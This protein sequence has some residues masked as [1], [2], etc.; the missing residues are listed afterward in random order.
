MSYKLPEELRKGRPG[1]ARGLAQGGQGQ[2]AVGCR[3]LAVDRGGRGE[4]AGL[5]GHRRQ[6]AEGD[7]ARC[8][9]SPT[10]SRTLGFRDVLLLGMGGSS[11]GPEVFAE[12]F[13]SKPG[14]PKL[15]VLNSTDPA[16]IRAFRMPRS[17]SRRTLFLV[18]SKSGSTLEPNIFKQYSYERAKQ[19][20]GAAEAPKRFVAITDPGS[21]LEKM[22][23]QRRVPPRVPRRAEHRRP[24]FGV[25]G[26]RHGA[27]G[28]DRHRPA[29]VSRKHGRDGAVLRGERAAGREPG[30]DP[31]RDPR[32]C[33]S[34]AGAT[35]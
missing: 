3:R 32:D 29:R 34:A 18:S 19:A 17:I 33:A 14:Y 8:R 23:L 24:L 21:S 7:R 27:G 13:G 25:V 5:A 11:L 10:T 22:A 30:R 6:A 26:F 9:T 20:V 2:A 28:G 35:R 1:S 15:H 12:T 31:R 4:M 16:Q